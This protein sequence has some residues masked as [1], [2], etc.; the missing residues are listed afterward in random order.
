MNRAFFIDL[1]LFS[2]VDGVDSKEEVHY[3]QF[4]APVKIKFDKN[5]EVVRNI[6]GNNKQYFVVRFHETDPGQYEFSQIQPTVTRDDVCNYYF[7]FVS[8]RFST[9]AIYS[10]DIIHKDHYEVPNT[11][12]TGKGIVSG[13]GYISLTTLV[14][15]ALLALRKKLTK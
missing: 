5:S 14:V 11:G 4:G 13:I 9:Y 6:I 3:P 1:N 10:R 15:L 8:D 12:I 7:S 2:M